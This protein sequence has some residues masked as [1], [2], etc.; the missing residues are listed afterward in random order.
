MGEEVGVPHPAKDKHMVIAVNKN[1]IIFFTFFLQNY[2]YLNQYLSS[3]NTKT[4][5]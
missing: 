4:Y 3:H 1:A 5:N 2:N